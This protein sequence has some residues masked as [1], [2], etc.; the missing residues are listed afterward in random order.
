MGVVFGGK[1]PW[2]ENLDCVGGEHGPDEGGSEDL[3]KTSFK[4]YVLALAE[5]QG[6]KIV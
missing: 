2:F 5:L 6:L 4:I 1:M 3:L